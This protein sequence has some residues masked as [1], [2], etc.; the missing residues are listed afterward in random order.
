MKIPEDRVHLIEIWQLPGYHRGVHSGFLVDKMLSGL[1]RVFAF[2]DK[3]NQP[4]LVVITDNDVLDWRGGAATINGVG[5]RHLF[6]AR[7]DWTCPLCRRLKAKPAPVKNRA[8]TR[9][10]EALVEKH[11]DAAKREG[12]HPN[13]KQLEK[14]AGELFGSYDRPLLRQT[15]ARETG[16][17][18]RGRPKGKSPK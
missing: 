1:C 7:A 3:G 8:S 11:V 5:Y 2:R 9:D 10:L 18:G 16:Y 17:R 14:Q 6:V 4:E 13:Q 15:L 12:R